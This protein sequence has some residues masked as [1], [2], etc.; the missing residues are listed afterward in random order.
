VLGTLTIPGHDPVTV[1]LSREEI[2][3][4]IRGQ[5]DDAM[6]LVNE[7]IRAGLVTGIDTGS[8]SAEEISLRRKQFSRLPSSETLAHVDFFVLAGGM[9]QMPLLQ[10]MLV[11]SGVDPDKMKMADRTNPGEAIARGLGSESLYQ[12]MNL[13]LPSFSFHLRWVDPET[14]QA[15]DF[16]LYKAHTR[17]ASAH[18]AFLGSPNFRNDFADVRH[19]FPKH[20]F[21]EIYALSL[22]GLRVKFEL[23]GEILDGLEF[24]FGHRKEPVLTISQSGEFFIRDT[25]ESLGQGY[26]IS[27]WPIVRNEE[28]STLKLK[29]RQRRDSRLGTA[30]DESQD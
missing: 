3:Q 19:L 28:N 14:D 27:G 17:L 24:A 10:Q 23:D 22:D 29:R 26:K 11:Q 15:R 20:G 25:S 5:I 7:S 12:R 13:H 18:A 4:S 2:A 6:T 9:V 30:D 16:E 8:L 21:G 1:R